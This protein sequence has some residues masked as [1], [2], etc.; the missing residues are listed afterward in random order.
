MCSGGWLRTSDRSINSRVLYRLSY[1]G[2]DDTVV[3]GEGFEPV[4]SLV[5]SQVPGH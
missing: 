2:A 5:K 4:L 3:G 1:A